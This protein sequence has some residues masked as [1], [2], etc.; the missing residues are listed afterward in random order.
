MPNTYSQIYLHYVFS[1]KYRQSLIHPEIE[2][3]LHKYISGIVSNLNQTL[4][5]I[6]GMPNHIHM[7]VRIRPALAPST[8]IQKV[9]A[10]SSRWL[11]NSHFF[12]HHFTWQVGSGIFSIGH[13]HVPYLIKYI[14]NQKPHH[15]KSK[16]RDE[17]LELLADNGISYEKEYLL[18]F[19][20]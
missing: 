14:D 11:N 2:L 15:A 19:H 16:F 10:N 4:I 13:R 17:Y 20:E 12:S 6:N 3:R 18:D 5:R 9:K 7:L 1:P 8:F